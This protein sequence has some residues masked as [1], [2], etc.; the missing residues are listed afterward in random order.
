[1]SS[2]VEVVQKFS[3]ANDTPAAPLN[4]FNKDRS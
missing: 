4:R 3:R 2:V 1:M